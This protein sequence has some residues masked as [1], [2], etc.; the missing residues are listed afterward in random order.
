VFAFCIKT[1]LQSQKNHSSIKLY[2]N[3]FETL[4]KEFN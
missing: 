4:K 1:I 2:L 3:L